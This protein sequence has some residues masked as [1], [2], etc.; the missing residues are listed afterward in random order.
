MKD[1][2]EEQRKMRERMRAANPKKVSAQD[3]PHAESSEPKNLRT[4]LNRIKILEAENASLR[5]QLSALENQPRQPKRASE[6]SENE[7]RHLFMKYS[8]V[9]RY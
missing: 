5:R 4:L 8:N 1:L 9:R 7:R 2:Q 3:R 6:M